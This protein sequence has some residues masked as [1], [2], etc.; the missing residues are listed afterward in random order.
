MNILVYILSQ[1]F[2]TAVKDIG[3]QVAHSPDIEIYNLCFVTGV[4][5]NNAL[6]HIFATCNPSCT[7]KLTLA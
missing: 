7:S 3:A 4:F 6:Y 1:L 2:E 5:A